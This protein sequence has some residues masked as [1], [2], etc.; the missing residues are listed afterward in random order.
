MPNES[1]VADQPASSATSQPPSPPPIHQASLNFDV[2]AHIAKEGDLHAGPGQYAGTRGKSEAMEGYA[3]TFTQALK[4]VGL[5][6][7]AGMRGSGSTPWITDGKLAGSRGQRAVV[8]TIAIELSGRDLAAYDVQYMAHVA[9]LGDTGWVE[10]G[11][12]CGTPKHAIEGLAVRI[13]PRQANYIT[14]MSRALSGSGKVLVITAPDKEGGPVMVSAPTGDDRQ[15][16][17]RRPVK[18][19]AGYVLISKK[20]PAKCLAR[21]GSAQPIVLKDTARID[22]DD[23]CI[24]LDDTV[25]GPYNAIRSW[26]NWELKLNMCGNPPY[27][28][29]DNLL[30]AYPWARASPNELWRTATRAYNLLSGA[31]GDAL[32]QMSESIYQ[33]CYPQIFRGQLSLPIPGVEAVVYDMQSAPV[34]SLETRAER[35]AA[36]LQAAQSQVATLAHD[37]L[38]AE[39]LVAA[40]P[41]TVTIRQFALEIKGRQPQKV[42]A[43]LLMA[44]RIES[45]LDRGVSLRLTLGDLKIPGHPDLEAV[46]KV[47]LVP[48]LLELLNSKLFAQIAIP[49]INLKGI[50]FSSPLIATRPPYAL[51]ASSKLPDQPTMPTDDN[52][53]KHTAFAVADTALLDSVGAAVLSDLKP[54]GT[55]EGSGGGFSARA[56][57]GV[58]FRDPHFAVTP[59]AGNTYG[60]AM[61]VTGRA[62]FHVD[63]LGLGFNLG[64]SANGHVNGKA[65][66]SVRNDKDIML[67]LE[68]LDQVDID[69]HFD[70]VPGFL[71]SIIGGI[72]NL[73]TPVVIG[74]VTRA[75]K[76]QQFEV[77]TLPA[78]TTSIAGKNFQIKFQQLTLGSRADRQGKP[79]VLGT[80]KPEVKLIP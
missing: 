51:I 54:S 14:L 67:A 72:L 41:I 5:R 70:D 23:T 16:W 78:I 68:T 34:F 33:G 15:L 35:P 48:A 69:W 63:F 61:N 74:V 50:D 37:S 79:L 25:P 46:L 60:I 80:A 44:A 27:M 58:G 53:P 71:D 42:A 32:N 24:W 77:Y 6:Y 57:Y 2:M 4:G 73:F 17:D 65:K 59:D 30:L 3:I 39:S 11:V 56:N 21:N 1:A 20:W 43:S 13:V 22:E 12:E 28:D 29:Q 47:A 18:G 75:L 31:D 10:N 49:G 9:H 36:L 64:A 76:G 40:S 66:V 62:T 45:N 55:W 8:E 7:R 38:S 52:W 19:A 26:N